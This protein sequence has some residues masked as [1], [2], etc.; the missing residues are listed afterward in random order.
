MK[1]QIRT[2]AALLGAAGTF[3]AVGVLLDRNNAG[4]SSEAAT[5]TAETKTSDPPKATCGA[6]GDAKATAK[7]G[8]ATMKAGLS[9]ASITRNGGGEVHAAF[10]ITTETVKNATRPPLNVALVIDRSGSMSGRIEHAQAAALGIVNRL[11]SQDR[12]SLIQYDDGADTLVHSIATDAK[13]K[14]R[15][16]AAINAIALGGGTN[17]HRGLEL[18]RDEVQRE[19]KQAQVSRVILLSDG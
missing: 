17:L 7:L 18:G 15:L 11:D 9:A 8:L 13:G 2:T 1:P 19:L 6:G 5:T 10:E 16:R 4:A 12:V 3:V 14:E